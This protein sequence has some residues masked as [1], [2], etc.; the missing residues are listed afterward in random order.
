[1][2]ATITASATDTGWHIEALGPD[3]PY[4]F[5]ADLPVCDCDG[6][7]VKASAPCS[8]HSHGY[9]ECKPAVGR[10]RLP[11]QSGGYHPAHVERFVKAVASTYGPRTVVPAIPKIPTA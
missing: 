3:S 11:Q 6:S 9:P 10:C 5:T 7:K 2:T 8:S 4:P 1:M